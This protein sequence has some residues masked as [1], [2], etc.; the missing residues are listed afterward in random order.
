MAGL[1]FDGLITGLNTEEIIQAL[2]SIKRAPAQR[3]AIRRDVETTR[4]NAIQ[5]LNASVLGIQVASRALGDVDTFRAREATSTNSEVAVAAAT[6]DAEL[7]SFTISVQ[8]LAQ[9]QQISSDPNNVF[10]DPDVA[11]NI[12]GTIQV[13]GNNVEIRDSDTLR[14]IANRISN[15]SGTVAAS[16]IEVDQGQ[17][18]LSVRSIQTGSETFTLADVSSNNVFE[19]LRLTQDSSFDT[20][21]NPITDGASSSEFNVRVLPI[22]DLL[23]LDTDVPSGTVSIGNGSG[24]FNVAIDLATQSLDDIATA[25]NDAAGL[26]GSTVTATVNE[27]EQGVFRLDIESGDATTPTFTDSNNVLETLGVLQ[28]SFLQVDQQGLD[29]EFTVNGIEV[30]RSTN[31]VSDVIDGVTLSLVSD[32]D[33][34]ASTTVSVVEAEGEAAAGIQTFVDAF[35]NTANF[36]RQFASFNAETQSA[37]VLLGD[38]SVLTVESTLSGLLTRQ[39]STLPSQFLSSLNGGSGVASGSIQITDRSGQSATVDLSAAETVEDVIAA[40]NFADI[41]V[42]A[43]TNRAGTGLVL[44]DTSGGFGSLAVN[45]VGGGTVAADLGIIGS[46]QSS[47]L[48]GSG[49]AQAEFLS[50]SEIGLS[51]NLDGTLSFSQV[52]FQDALSENFE[53]VEAFFRQ[54]GGFADIAEQATE[55]LTDATDGVLTVRAEG[56]ESSIENFQDSIEAIE[57]RIVSEEDRLRRQFTALEQSVSQLQSQGEFLLTQLSQLNAN[58]NR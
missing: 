20:V 6:S 38:S 48:Q 39:I 5:G 33:P 35:N 21:A 41:G 7:G 1:S 14:D 8:Q 34:G 52:E 57:A 30:V 22:G 4:L 26:A 37:G 12:E 27:I 31:N 3:L 49:V 47:R 24:S 56:I 55:R 16:V 11:L 50:L 18:R 2:V 46:T 29:S 17:F 58:N 44:V 28:A 43:Q 13:N 23:N 10:T 54:S 51:F 36:I 32:D 15:A 9:A 42:E 25:I 19:Q 53:S 40:I 45:E